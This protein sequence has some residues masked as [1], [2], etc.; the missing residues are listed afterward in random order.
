MRQYCIA[1]NLNISDAVVANIT[2]YAAL[3]ALIERI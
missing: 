1:E 3:R 2:T